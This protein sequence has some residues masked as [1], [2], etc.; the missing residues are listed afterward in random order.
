MR[1]GIELYTVIMIPKGVSGKMP[2]VLTR[3]PYSAAGRVS[4]TKSPDVAMALPAADEALVTNGYIR[5]YQDVRGRF[6]SKGRYTMTMPTIGPF[7]KGKVDQVTD[8][9]DTVDWLIKNVDGNSGRVGI[10]GTSYDGLLTL[11]A[12]LDPHPA[13][14]AAVPVNSMVDS[15]LGDDFYRHGA[16]RTVMFEYVYRQTASRSASKGIPWGYRDFYS[17]ILEAGS[18]GELGRRYGADK[19]PAWNRLIEHP[20]YDA[21]WQ[22]QALHKLLEKAPRRVPVLTVHSLFDQEDLYGPVLSHEV[23]ARRDRSGNKTHLAIGPWCHGQQSGEGSALGA[24]KWGADTS[25]QFR[26]EMLMPFWEHHLKGHK[27]AKP[28]PKVLAFETGANQWRQYDNWPP[29]GKT[30]SAKLYLQSEGGLSFD[31]PKKDGTTHTEY[32][33]DPAKPVPYR[34]RPIVP[35]FSG[36]G[37]TWSRWLVDDQRPFADR[38]D[39]LVFTS[40]TL[41]TPVTVSGEITTTLFASTTGTDAD[42]VVKLIDQYP[43][44]VPAEPEM[45]GYQFMI[46]GDI[47]RGRYRESFE[48]AAP[49]PPGEI[50]PYRVIMPHVHHTFQPGH[51][52][53]IQIQSSWFPLCDRNPQT[54]VENIA[55]AKP[56]DYQKANHRIHHVAGAASFIELPIQHDAKASRSRSTK[57]RRAGSPRS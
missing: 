53:M 16:F 57:A 51:R 55:W 7:N 21:Y 28:L 30:R 13:L 20:A 9:W 39:V 47:L 52:I 33:S 8:A 34:V 40:E 17:A 29:T 25:L 45:G 44:E 2:I 43:N 46:S 35:T 23:L 42:W 14:K 24:L 36:A 37:S 19:L 26:R 3:T 12:L 31:A 5:V 6:G 18:I 27:P 1:D 48:V 54:F 15:W 56:D 11:M 4:R 49:I 50:L 10:T 41:E 22:D 32:T 38:T